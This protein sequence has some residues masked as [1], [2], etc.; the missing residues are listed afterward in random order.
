MPSIR[1]YPQTPSQDVLMDLSK[2]NSFS[3]ADQETKELLNA[4]C[5][6]TYDNM[7]VYHTA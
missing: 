7:M 1:A 6:T 2:N 5:H 3:N 4:V